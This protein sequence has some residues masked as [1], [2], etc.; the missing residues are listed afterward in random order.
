MTYN[1]RNTAI[2]M[3]VI[4]MVLCFT[5]GALLYLTM[6]VRRDIKRKFLD[7]DED[8]S[9]EENEEEEKEKLV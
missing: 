8:E 4:C 9:E 5:V 6:K 7:V 3:G 1:L 2:L